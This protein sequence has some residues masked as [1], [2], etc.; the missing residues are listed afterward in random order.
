MNII[1]EF[2]EPIK[3]NSIILICVVKNELLLLEY[4]L[5]HYK[6]IGITHFIFIDNNS[7]DGSLEYIQNVTDNILLYSTN[8]VQS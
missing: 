2:T 6:T 1:K 8:D 4:F 7:T 3:D 5:T